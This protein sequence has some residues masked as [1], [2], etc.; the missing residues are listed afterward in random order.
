MEF[1]FLPSKHA[2]PPSNRP[3][4]V[5][6]PSRRH[7]DERVARSGRD[8]ER[9]PPPR[10]RDSPG[11]RDYR[12]PISPPRR[13]IPS[14]PRRSRRDSPRRRQT[15]VARPAIQSFCTMR[16]PRK[17]ARRLSSLIC[18]PNPLPNR[19]RSIHLAFPAHVQSRFSVEKQS[20]VSS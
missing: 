20:G 14:P 6:S 15:L 10:R 11:R 13:R 16:A 9:P 4:R 7:R 17:V 3:T 18:K 2:P 12:R 1:P 19:I 5:P 8:R